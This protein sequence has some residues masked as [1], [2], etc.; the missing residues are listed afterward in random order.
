MFQPK[1][2]CAAVPLLHLQAQLVDGRKTALRK[3]AELF[4]FCEGFPLNVKVAHV[5]AERDLIEAELSMK[6]VG[7]FN[8]WRESLLDRLLVLGSSASEV[9]TALERARLERDV[10][11]VESLGMFEHA[12]V[13]KLGTDAAGLISKTGSIL[14]TSRFAVFNPRR[15]SGFLKSKQDSVSANQ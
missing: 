7:R 11:D 2:V 3:M 5:D 9:K 10:I 13:C 14:R 12:L 15:I 8:N 4:G 1:V 6:Q